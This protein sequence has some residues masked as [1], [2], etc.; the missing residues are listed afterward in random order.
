MRRWLP[1]ALVLP[2][3]LALLLLRARDEDFPPENDATAYALNA[4]NLVKYGGLKEKVIWHTLVGVAPLPRPANEYWMPMPSLL[5]APVVA[6]SRSYRAEIAMPI[7]FG[8]ACVALAYLV[9]LALVEDRWLAAGVALGCAS[10][11]ELLDYAVCSDSTVFYAAFVAGAIGCLARAVARRDDAAALQRRWSIAA[12]LLVGCTV[13]TR[14]DGLLGWAIAL[15]LFALAAR[16]RLVDGLSRRQWRW[17]GL[18]AAVVLVPWVIRSLVVFHAPWNP[19]SGRALWLTRYED[20]Y[21]WPSDASFATWWS[22]LKV[23]PWAIV[24]HKL[25]ITK[26]V[27]AR[28]AELAAPSWALVL[29]AVGV[30]ASL[31][32]R[33]AVAAVATAWALAMVVAYGGVADVVGEFAVVRSSVSLLPFL[34]GWTVLGAREVAGLVAPAR[35]RAVAR[36]L[37]LGVAAWAVWSTVKV[38]RARPVNRTAEEH[39]SALAA[40]ERTLR[41]QEVPATQPILT[42]RPWQLAYVTGRPTMIVPSNG[43]EATCAAA[44]A[45]GA[46]YL[47]LDGYGY[48]DQELKTIWLGQRDPRFEDVWQCGPW[49]LFRLACDEP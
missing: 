5:M 47:L 16:A 29:T 25:T 9:G 26:L 27:I 30:V 28:L 20:L 34:S 10:S 48:L 19:A 4:R 41:K 24:A 12:G 2:V 18:G 15:A 42:A 49:R 3:A 13:L 35:R 17:L 8:L 31:R 39:R 45:V 14:N 1:L 44:R 22:A 6:F 36:V 32:A 43:A 46:R 11:K 23:D 21:R 37:V 38:E 7:V 33:R 40:L